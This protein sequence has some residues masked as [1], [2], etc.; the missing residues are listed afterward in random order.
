MGRK[1]GVAAIDMIVNEDFGRMVSL[2]QGSIASVPLK[3]VLDKL[4][5]VNVEKFYNTRNYRCLDEVL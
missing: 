5:L 3:K 1:F 4:N 2:R